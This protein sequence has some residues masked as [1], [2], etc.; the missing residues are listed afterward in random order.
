MSPVES[1]FQPG[2]PIAHPEYDEGVVLETGPDGYLRAFFGGSGE[3]RV[4]V[5]SIRRH[6]SRT[7]R[8]LRAVDGGTECAPGLAQLRGACTAGDE[9]YLVE[10][11]LQRELKHRGAADGD[12]SYWAEL[13]GYVEIVR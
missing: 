10:P 1:S 3:R 7:E 8:I 9:E 2:E 6:L 12:Q 11:T 4:P 13:I 5:K